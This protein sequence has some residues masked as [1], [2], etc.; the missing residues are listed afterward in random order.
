[1]SNRRIYYA[2]QALG[3]APFANETYT[4]VQGLQSVGINTKFNLEQV[5]EIGQ[6]SIY[7]NVENLPDLEV[8]TEKVLDGYPLVYHLAT[9]GAADSTLVGRSNQRANM[10]LAV[11][12]DTAQLASGT[13]LTQ[14]FMSGVYVSQV[15]YSVQVDGNAT[16]SCSFVGN[17]KAWKTAAFTFDGFTSGNGVTSTGPASASGVNRRQHL[18]MSSCLFPKSIPGIDASGLNAEVSGSFSASI[19]SIRVSAN[20]GRDQ[21][22]ELGHKSP[23]FRYV[24]FP[25]EVTTTIEALSKQGD[26]VEGTEAGSQPNGD[27]TV[28]ETMRFKMQE[29]TAIDLGSKNRL[30]SVNYG[31]ANAGSRGG[32]ATMTF[33]YTTFNDFD[34]RHPADPGGFAPAF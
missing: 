34:V 4:A 29:G 30:S 3:I 24:N 11:F 23:F 13:P 15:E 7:E 9:Q 19:Q 25:V 14:C 12:D 17:N 8:T 2:C 10:S 6:L 1:M 21:L 22:L 32:N 28:E 5:F 18:L 33:T 26:M 31:G 20:L 27:N 16:E